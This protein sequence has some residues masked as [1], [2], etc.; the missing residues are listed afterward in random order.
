MDP[1]RFISTIRATFAAP[2]ILKD[3]MKIRAA[4]MLPVRPTS[5]PRIR[6]RTSGTWMI[7]IMHN[8]RQLKPFDQPYI[9]VNQQLGY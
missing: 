5:M 9:R 6:V 2:S 7:I 8:W 3:F 4:R 1:V